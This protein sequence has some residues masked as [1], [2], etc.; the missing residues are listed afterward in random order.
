V[1]VS[2]ITASPVVI[3]SSRFPSDDELSSEPFRLSDIKVAQVW[4]F[5]GC[6]VRVRGGSASSTTETVLAVIEAVLKREERI[7]RVERKLRQAQNPLTGRAAIPDGVR[8]FVWR[9]DQGRCVKCGNN[10]K[11]EFDYIIPVAKGGS[12]TAR[13]LQLLCEPC[14]RSKGCEV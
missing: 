8:E 3:P 5:R 9:R 1:T 4:L 12:N 14:N 11:L 2:G 13:N 6:A 10:E 7:R